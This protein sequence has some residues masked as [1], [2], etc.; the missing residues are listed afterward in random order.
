MSWAGGGEGWLTAALVH[1]IA[2]C[3]A[4]IGRLKVENYGG[5]SWAELRRM[6][7]SKNE[8]TLAHTA[9]VFTLRIA[10][11]SSPLGDGWGRQ[12]VPK[13]RRR[14]YVPELLLDEERDGQ[15]WATHN[16][17]ICCWFDLRNKK[18]KK[19]KGS[20]W[21]AVHVFGGTGWTDGSAGTEHRTEGFSSLCVLIFNHPQS[22]SLVV[23]ALT[24]LWFDCSSLCVHRGRVGIEGISNWGRLNKLT[25]WL[26]D[27]STVREIDLKAW[28]R[29]STNYQ[30][31]WLIDC[32]YCGIRWAENGNEG[33]SKL[34]GIV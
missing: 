34:T 10:R 13:R 2:S 28:R 8:F 18:W 30:C 31:W 19:K 5:R 21:R 16:S 1:F 27:R 33:I 24:G 11:A 22:S 7:K 3:I 6:M 29:I 14:D 32:W 26:T 4:T 9:F 17:S 23:V 20:S 15:F 25:E 12:V